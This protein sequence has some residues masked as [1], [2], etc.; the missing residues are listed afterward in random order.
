MKYYKKRIFILLMGITGI[1]VLQS[2]RTKTPWNPYLSAKEKPSDKQ[3]KE[4]Q[5]QIRIGTKAYAKLMIKNKKS[6]QGNIQK[7][8]SSKKHYERITKPKRNKNINNKK[9]HF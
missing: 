3:R 1:T 8:T 7:S 4:E 6:I 9:W 2:C 5:K